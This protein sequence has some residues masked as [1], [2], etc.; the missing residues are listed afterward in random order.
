M[1]KK[2]SFKNVETLGA[3]GGSACELAID[4]HK[5]AEKGDAVDALL[6]MRNKD[7]A[8]A[9][10][11]TPMDTADI[12][13]LATYLNAYSNQLVWHENRAPVLEDEGSECDKD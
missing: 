3:S 11:Y 4:L 2:T 6:I 13:E 8:L 10:N 1:P 9:I 5:W 12:T 7:G